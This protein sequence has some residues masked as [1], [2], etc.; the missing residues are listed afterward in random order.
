MTSLEIFTIITIIFIY[1]M[2][3]PSGDVDSPLF[4]LPSEQEFR[5]ILYVISYVLFLI[6]FGFFLWFL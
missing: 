3:Y 1:K 6:V 4:G 5:Q 2:K